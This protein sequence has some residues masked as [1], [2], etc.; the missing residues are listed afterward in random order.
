MMQGC[1]RTSGSGTTRTMSAGAY[2]RKRG[3]E[4]MEEQTLKYLGPLKSLIGTWEGAS[5]NDVAPGDD[6]GTEENKFRERIVLE[7]T[8]LTA[9][10]EQELYGLRYHM[11]AWRIGESEPFH[12]ETGYWLWDSKAKQVF[13]CFTIPRGMAVVAGGTVAADAKKF[14]LAAMF[15]EPDFG[16]S[17]NPFL[18]REFKTVKFELEM[19]FNEDGSFIY[20]QLTSIQI[21]GQEKLFEHRDR[22]T[23]MRVEP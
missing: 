3:K 15:G 13:K 2:Y 5:G 11:Q 10:H 9:N 20:D 19:I 8:G 23:L 22:N 6:R 17:S 4:I 12:D 21:K 16:I 18:D 14:K 1:R 7:P